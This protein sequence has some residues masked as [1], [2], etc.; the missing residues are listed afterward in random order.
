[1]GTLANV[2]MGRFGEPCSKVKES[3]R[4]SGLPGLGPTGIVDVKVHV[5]K[6]EADGI[7]PSS[8][9]AGV[10]SLEGRKKS[11]RK[12]RPK[13]NTPGGTTLAALPTFAGNPGN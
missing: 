9:A 1:M 2:L 4:S 10:G 12:S 13:S 8:Y 3:R 7:G 11:N 6:M 5:D